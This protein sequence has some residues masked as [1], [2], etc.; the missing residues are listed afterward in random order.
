MIPFVVLILLK[1]NI[2]RFLLIRSEHLQLTD[3]ERHPYSPPY[4]PKKYAEPGVQRCK[5]IPQ[6]SF[7]KQ[8]NLD[9]M[10]QESLHVGENSTNSTKTKKND[11]SDNPKDTNDA[12]LHEGLNIGASL[13]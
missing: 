3:V 13:Y 1:Y 7:P 10:I 8:K 2:F 4:S 12:D 9:T 6:K 11:N 5:D